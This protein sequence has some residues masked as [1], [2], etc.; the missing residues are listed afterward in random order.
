ML[1]EGITHGVPPH[2]ELYIS[3]CS[4]CMSRSV[5]YCCFRLLDADMLSAL[6]GHAGLACRWIEDFRNVLQNGLTD[7]LTIPPPDKPGQCFCFS[8]IV[9]E[10][11]NA[12][13][14]AYSSL[15]R[16]I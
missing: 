16:H 1:P 10:S 8:W 4:S 3:L 13:Q 6:P 12:N 5:S 14:P 9:S 11:V 7:I 2:N 15:S